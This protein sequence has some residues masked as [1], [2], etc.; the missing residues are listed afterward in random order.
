MVV[1]DFAADL[2]HLTMDITRTFNISGK[3][4]PEQ[5][6]WYAV[7]LESQKARSRLHMLKPGNTYEQVA[8]AGKCR[9]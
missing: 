2:D 9:V 7:D 5:A 6:K 4:T 3:F 1:F 8:D